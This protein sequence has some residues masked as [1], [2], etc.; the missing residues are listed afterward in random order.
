MKKLTK[1]LA[2][3]LVTV[4]LASCGKYSD[5]PEFTVLTKKMRI[6]GEWDTKTI[7]DSDGTTTDDTSNDTFTMEKD[8]TYRANYGTVS[9]NGSWEFTSDKEKIRV[10]YTNGSLSYTEDYT[11]KRLTNKEL[12]FTNSDGDT[13]KCEKK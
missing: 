11:I 13:I 1:F 10:T 4:A 5:G 6:T 9:V 7:I 8:G 2:L 12:W 3:A